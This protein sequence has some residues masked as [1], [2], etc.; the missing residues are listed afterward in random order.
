MIVYLHTYFQ[1]PNW[2]IFKQDYVLAIFGI[3]LYT[4]IEKGKSLKVKV[5]LRTHF[6]CPTEL[7]PN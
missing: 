7:F 1:H 4:G 3:Y 5:Y 2:A 6:Q